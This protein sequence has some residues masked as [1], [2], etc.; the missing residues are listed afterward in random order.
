M[1]RSRRRLEAYNRYNIV[2]GRM[3]KY[4]VKLMKRNWMAAIQ[5]G[6]RAPTQP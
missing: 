6:Y 2:F 4:R 1:K 3:G 5:A